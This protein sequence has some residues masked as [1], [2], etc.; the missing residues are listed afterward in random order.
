MF[1]WLGYN[2]NITTITTIYFLFGCDL[3]LEFKLNAVDTNLRLRRHFLLSLHESKSCYYF[4]TYALHLFIYLFYV[5]LQIQA[6]CIQCFR[7]KNHMHYQVQS[8]G[9]ILQ[10]LALI[11]IS[12][13]SYMYMCYLP[14]HT[15]Q[16]SLGLCVYLRWFTQ[17]CSETWQ[18]LHKALRGASR[19]F[20]VCFAFQSLHH[21]RE[22]FLNAPTRKRTM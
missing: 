10:S 16:L 2:N 20:T 7:R 15:P 18:S 17:L 3:K 13:N 9:L 6:Q 21:H 5:T 12:L 8:Y 19:A 4:T 11:F 1:C 22:T 14:C